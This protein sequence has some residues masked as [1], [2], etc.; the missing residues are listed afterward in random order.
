[1]FTGIVLEVGKCDISSS[2]DANEST[3]AERWGTSAFFGLEA[4]LVVEERGNELLQ[5]VS[6]FHMRQKRFSNRGP[7]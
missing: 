2:S 7:S 6:C 3:L 4:G 5:S 1:M